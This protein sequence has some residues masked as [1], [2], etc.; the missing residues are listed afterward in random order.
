MLWNSI[1]VFMDGNA[2]KEWV[3]PIDEHGLYLQIIPEIIF[4]GFCPCDSSSN[5]LGFRKARNTPAENCLAAIQTAV[6]A[7]G[8]SGLTSQG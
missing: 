8:L 3:F 6:K 2:C 5:P 7:D 1:I 4:V